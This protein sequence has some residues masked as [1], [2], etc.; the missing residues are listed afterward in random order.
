[1]PRESDPSRYGIRSDYIERPEPEYFDDSAYDRSI[2]WQPDV[3]RDARNTARALA[4]PVI[5]DIGAGTGDKL[6]ELTSDFPA[7]GLD[8][9]A[10]LD[11]CRARHPNIDWREYDAERDDALPPSTEEVA[12]AV[13]ICADVIEHV[14]RPERLLGAVADALDRGAHLCLLS[15]PDRERTWGPAHLGPPPN[16]HDVREW[17][18]DEL[19]AFAQAEGIAAGIA[20]WTRAHHLSLTFET[21][22][23]VL[24]RDLTV[25]DKAGL[26]SGETNATGFVRREPRPL[27]IGQTAS[28]RLR[29]AGRR[30][31]S[32]HIP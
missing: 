11:T 27:A 25:L 30:V 7:I 20:T 18:R 31:L 26:L 19:V 9:G 2:V 14:P 22:E 32:R 1:M 4:A 6:S 8:F 29:R 15:T 13:L 21:I 3:Y 12:G 23:L 10:N 16:P 5:V 28:V 24:V 17:T